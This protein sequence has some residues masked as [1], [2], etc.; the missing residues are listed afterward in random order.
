MFPP[1][2]FSIFFAPDYLPQVTDLNTIHQWVLLSI[3]FLLYSASGKAL[4]VDKRAG[5]LRGQ[6]IIPPCAYDAYVLSVTL[7]EKLLILSRCS[8]L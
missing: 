7:N 1:D 3:G 8:C 5:Q 4:I 6:T 2:V